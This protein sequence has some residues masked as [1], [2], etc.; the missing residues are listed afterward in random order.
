ML[1]VAPLPIRIRCTACPMVTSGS[2]LE[3]APT[4][5]AW[6]LLDGFWFCEA[7]RSAAPYIVALD[8]ERNAHQVTMLRLDEANDEIARHRVLL[9][10]SGPAFAALEALGDECRCRREA[11]LDEA[12]ANHAAAM[13][14][15][16]ALRCGDLGAF[17]D[18]EL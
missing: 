2:L 7:C 8:R 9:A 18:G 4:T 13:A 15:I 5:M 14:E 16:G 17:H 11:D 10:A 1:T 3:L 6:L 12:A